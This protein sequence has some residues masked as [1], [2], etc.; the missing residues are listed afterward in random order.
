MKK[1]FLV[2]IVAL[3][4]GLGMTS[5]KQN[6]APAGEA[7]EAEQT[8]APADP[9]KA[10][11]DLTAKAKAEGANWSVDEWKDAFKVA[12]SAVAPTMKEIAEITS[13][14]KTKEGEEPDTAKLAKAFEQM[15][16][17]QEKFA[18]IEDLASQFDSIS[19]SYPNGKTVADDK[20]F[21]KAMMKE[22]GLPEDF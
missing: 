14:L 11:T 3:A 20:E 5:C 8:E 15:K 9:I 1:L 18:P 16:V 13:D 12:M 17:L 4:M 7:A 19:K 10:L 21:E 6:A 22:L 2:A